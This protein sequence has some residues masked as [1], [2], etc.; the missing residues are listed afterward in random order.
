MPDSHYLSLPPVLDELERTATLGKR[1][2]RLSE[3]EFE[4]LAQLLRYPEQP[5][6]R[7]TLKRAIG[8]DDDTIADRKL[9][10]WVTKVIRK[11]NV[12]WPLFSIVRFVEPDSY[13]YSEKAPPKKP[14]RRKA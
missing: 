12:L 14:E 10:A 13:V 2:E 11:T 9:D 8:S 1:C 3:L 4:I 7:D 6:S 5:M